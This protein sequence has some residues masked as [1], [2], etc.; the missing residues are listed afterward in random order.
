M[1]RSQGFSSSYRLEGT[2]GGCY[3]NARVMVEI[4]RMR[5]ATSMSSNS[6]KAWPTLGQCFNLG[7]ADDRRN[8]GSKIKSDTTA[9]PQT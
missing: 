9:Y 7:F 4:Q 6:A 5:I 1:S 3:C 2:R 8:A